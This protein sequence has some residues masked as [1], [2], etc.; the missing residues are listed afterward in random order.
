MTGTRMV[1]GDGT[2]W[3]QRW[4][5]SF[6]ELA[7]LNPCAPVGFCSGVFDDQLQ[8][9][10]VLFCFCESTKLSKETVSNFDAAGR[11]ALNRIVNVKP[12]PM[13]SFGLAD[14]ERD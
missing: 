10:L 13:P 6:F 5:R 9:A 14:L 1:P 12:A 7:A 3:L 8:K 2:G 11:I 4:A